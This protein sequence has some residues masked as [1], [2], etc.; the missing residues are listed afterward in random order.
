MELETTQ[1]CW[2][3]HG[4]LSTSPVLLPV[5]YFYPKIPPVLTSSVLS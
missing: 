5:V 4:Q 3:K 1:D 2:L